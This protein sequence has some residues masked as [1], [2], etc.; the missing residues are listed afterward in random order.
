[1]KFL[2]YLYTYLE[3]ITEDL[4]YINGFYLYNK[5]ISE[6]DVEEDQ[7]IGLEGFEIMDFSDLR[8]YLIVKEKYFLKVLKDK[9][10]LKPNV[11]YT[12]ITKPN[13]EYTASITNGKVDF[14][15]KYKEVK[16]GIVLLKKIVDRKDLKIIKTLEDLNNE[17]YGL[18]TINRSGFLYVICYDL[19]SLINYYKKEKD[20]ASPILFFGKI[21][22]E[23]T[24]VLNKKI[25]FGSA[26]VAMTAA[27]QRVSGSN[28]L[29]P[30][31]TYFNKNKKII[32]DRG[33][34]SDDAEWVWRSFYDGDKA[35]KKFHPIDNYRDPITP[36]KK[37]DGKLYYTLDL[38]DEFDDIKNSKILN[39]KSKSHKQ[40]VNLLKELR[41]E[42]P[43]NWI[44]KLDKSKE[45]EV[46]N[47]IDI[48]KQN[49]ERIKSSKKNQKKMSNF[50]NK[51]FD[52]G[53]QLFKK[54]VV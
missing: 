10:E 13:D 6:L 22:N 18:F 26:I 28:T 45:S 48:L 37:D 20:F 43:L 52:L 34:V 46:K 7:I 23:E 54:R 41:E 17:N 5:I 2:N 1:M 35:I 50:E 36:T 12:F 38:R 15:K 19:N 30:I 51:L 8:S 11:E 3:S 32:P 42:D 29:Y 9:I 24:D 44:Y 27:S 16:N 14:I 47:I 53:I 49:H 21:R 31:L 40:K 39:D 33:S 25:P 4:T